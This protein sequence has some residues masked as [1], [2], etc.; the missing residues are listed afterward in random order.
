MLN[1]IVLIGRLT[2]DDLRFTKRENLLQTL[3]LVTGH[4]EAN[5]GKKKRILSES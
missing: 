4:T 5:K 2:K 1:R 3:R